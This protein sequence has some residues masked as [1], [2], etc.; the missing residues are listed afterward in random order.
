MVEAL[1]WVKNNIQYF[2]GDAKS[3]TMVGQ[4]AGAVA[5]GL[6]TMSSTTNGLFKRLILQSGSPLQIQ[7]EDRSFET[8]QQV[9]LAVGCAEDKNT[10]KEN[11]ETVLECLQGE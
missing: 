1:K 11:P 6:M 7:D 10:L 2:G 5:A 3:V 9:A 4:S 8:S